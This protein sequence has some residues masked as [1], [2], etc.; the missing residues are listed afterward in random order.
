M[1]PEYMRFE[2]QVHKAAQILSLT[3]INFGDAEEDDIHTT[4]GYNDGEGLLK[5]LPVDINGRK[6]WLALNVDEWKL[7]HWEGNEELSCIDFNGKS[8]E[9]LHAAWRDW[10]SSL[11]AEASKELNYNLPE[12]D[13][14]KFSVFEEFDQKVISEWK[15]N[16][17]TANRVF[18]DLVEWCGIDSPIRIWPHH[19]DTGGY[20]V[21]DA[22]DKGVR[23]SIGVGLAV[24]DSVVSEPYYYLYGWTRDGEIDFS[25]APKLKRGEW[26]TKEWKG[27][28]LSVSTL[29]NQSEELNN[30]CHQSFTFLKEQIQS[31]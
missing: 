30:F 22:D 15:E 5:G 3:A 13:A 17:A 29:T 1:R 7:S 25:K 20:F 9:E 16:R 28:V 27:A 10:L 19:F 24:A 8:W 2:A 23:A 4:L 11:G 26:R 18:R 6:L 14:Y 12:S 21:I 31:T